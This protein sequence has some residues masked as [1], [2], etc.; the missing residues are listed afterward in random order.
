MLLRPLRLLSRPLP[1]LDGVATKP[2]DPSALL[3]CSTSSLLCVLLVSPIVSAIL[4]FAAWVTSAAWLVSGM[5]NHESIADVSKGERR[6]ARNLF[7][8]WLNWLDR[9]LKEGV[10]FDDWDDEEQKIQRRM[11]EVLEIKAPSV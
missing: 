10:D 8:M 1:G 7:S 11:P 9:P 5:L 4:G 3:P 6:M 2:D